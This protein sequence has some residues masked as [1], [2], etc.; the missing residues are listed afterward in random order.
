MSENKELPNENN[1]D[2]SSIYKKIL[3]KRS[4]QKKEA[5]KEEV[6]EQDEEKKLSKEERRN[7]SFNDWRDTLTG[8][9]G[10]DIDYYK[11]SKKEKKKFKKWILTEVIPEDPKNVKKKKRN[12]N[13]EFE[14]ELNMLKNIVADQN[15][16]ITDLYK[17]YQ[18]AA[19]PSTKDGAR[20]DKTLVELASAINNSRGNVLG[21]L[22]EIGNIKKTIADLYMKQRKLD[23]D[24]SGNTSQQNEDDIGLMG[25]NLASSLF[26]DMRPSSMNVEEPSG[27]RFVD[28]PPII[29]QPQNPIVNNQ[30]MM[31]T[32]DPSTWKDDSLLNPYT[33]YEAIPHDIVV[34]WDKESA[35]GRFKAI[36]RD[37]GEELI[38]CPVPERKIESVDFNNRMA[39]DMFDQVYPL[40]ILGEG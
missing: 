40:H 7:K 2:I 14:P 27:I 20:L 25:S 30:S 16:F 21:M 8:I 4:L 35:S 11:S 39:K 15:R 18:I 24:M 10:D 38:G 19:G 26:G 5:E 37:N 17:R 23:A 13:K 6:E 1:N 28:N 29:N 12:Y 3:E 32:F 9:L 33:H 22:K 34:E 36:R 31:S